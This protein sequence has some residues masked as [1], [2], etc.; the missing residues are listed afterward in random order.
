MIWVSCR[1]ACIR[2]LLQS[3]TTNTE[4]LIL[5]FVR[6]MNTGETVLWHVLSRAL[7]RTFLKKKLKASLFRLRKGRWLSSIEAEA[8]AAQ[9]RNTRIH[10]SIIKDYAVVA[11][12][13]SDSYGVNKYVRTV[14]FDSF[15]PPIPST[16]RF[17]R[18]TRNQKWIL[19]RTI[20]RPNK[21]HVNEP[22]RKWRMNN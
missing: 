5:E 3:P 9:R 11:E 4:T 15:P 8:T 22:E 20:S 17:N 19:L 16:R 21:Q 6:G 10:R 2:T 18:C 12:L 14:S 7:A 1:A 13:H